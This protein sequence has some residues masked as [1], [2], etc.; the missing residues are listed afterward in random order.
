MADSGGATIVEFALVAPVLLLIIM[1]TFDIGMQ[2]YTTSVL[3]GVMQSAGRQFSLE[4]AQSRQAPLE[5]LVTTQVRR[6]APSA[7]ITFTRKAYFDFADI[8]EPEEYDDMNGDGQCNDDEPFE[9]ANGNGQ[10]DTDRG[11]DGFGH[12]RDAVLFTARVRYTRL[13]PVQAML[14]GSDQVTLEASTILRN[15][16]YDGQS[17][18]VSLGNCD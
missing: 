1:G 4:D 8:G 6:V 10:W 12:A 13:F 11:D 16:P 9:D 3:Q 17:R 5:Q 18:T 2:I 14:G 7:Q 15:Q